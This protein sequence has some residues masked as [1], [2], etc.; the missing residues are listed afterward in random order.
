MPFHYYVYALGLLLLSACVE[1][2]VVCS[3]A[4]EQQLRLQFQRLLV[5]QDIQ[6]R[7][8]LAVQDTALVIR[9]ISIEQSD[10]LFYVQDTTST[11][12][13][14]LHPQR[15]TLLYSIDIE[16]MGLR[17]LQVR[18]RRIAELV[19]PECGVKMNYNEL[20]VL[21]NDFDSAYV[22]QDANKNFVIR[23]FIRAN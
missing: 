18:Y 22:S 5:L 4:I 10:S 19:S 13:L 11:A 17:K 8:S 2:P 9:Q 20:S 23:L 1:L 21:Q 7:D 3:G 6:G 15:D 14:P 16:G 12:R